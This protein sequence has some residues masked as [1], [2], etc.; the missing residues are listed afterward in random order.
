[1][2]LLLFFSVHFCV[3][4][5]SLNHSLLLFFLRYYFFLLRH[6]R[7]CLLFFAPHYIFFIDKGIKNSMGATSVCFCFV[8]SFTTRSVHYTFYRLG[9]YLCVCL[10]V[11]V[12][13]FSSDLCVCVWLCVS[14]SLLLLFLYSLL[15]L[16]S[17]HRC[18]VIFS[19]F[20]N[21]VNTFIDLTIHFLLLFIS[22]RFTHT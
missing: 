15:L 20:C 6:R 9:C 7:R 2:V 13:Y 11:Y 22:I 17:N 18:N 5:H 16:F 14:L 8:T 3:S 1:M 12:H 4:C 10:C 19:H 21:F